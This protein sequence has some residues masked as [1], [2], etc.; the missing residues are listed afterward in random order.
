MDSLF[1]APAPVGS[2][3]V[4][5]CHVRLRELRRFVL[6]SAKTLQARWLSEKER[7]WLGRAHDV[8][9]DLV[10]EGDQ[11]VTPRNDTNFSRRARK[12]QG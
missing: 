12:R 11:V 1:T 10:R 6:R 8:A 4:T 7:V 5:G 3:R 2:S 9:T